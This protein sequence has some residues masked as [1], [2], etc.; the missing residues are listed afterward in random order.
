MLE[1]E[2]V[3]T[4]AQQTTASSPTF[5]ADLEAC[6]VSATQVIPDEAFLCADGQ[7]SSKGATAEARA[8]GMRVPR[9]FAPEAG[10]TLESIRTDGLAEWIRNS[11]PRLLRLCNLEENWDA[12]GS[13]APTPSLVSSV[14][15]LLRWSE[16]D[17]LAEPEIVPA[18]GGG[19]QLEWYMGDRELELEFRTE[20]SVEYLKSDNASG[21]DTEGLIESLD[22]LRLCLAWVSEGH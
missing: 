7:R 11:V 14:V 5:L 20:G 17:R 15:L 21:T 13:D 10:A 18:L 19:V 3:M 1:E 4:P 12:R 22:D 6:S 2:D 8:R 9:L 16:I